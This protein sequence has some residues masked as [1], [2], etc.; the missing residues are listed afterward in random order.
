MEKHMLVLKHY[1]PRI[2]LLALAALMVVACGPR[3]GQPGTPATGPGAEGTPT[4]PA[5]PP[6]QAT[7]TAP[8]SSGVVVGTA[9]VEDIDVMLL[10]SFPV[11]VRVVA[12]GYLQDSCTKI[13]R[14]NQTRE[15]NTFKVGIITERPSGAMCT[16]V[17]VPFEETISLDVAGLKAGT[18]TV[19]VNG[20]TETFEMKVDNSLP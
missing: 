10:E 4:P 2:S 17:I 13:A 11:Q 14:V 20:V 7:P 9:V 3:G 12:R 18:Y 6:Q 15:G 1:A 8:P 19:D 5:T 16:Q